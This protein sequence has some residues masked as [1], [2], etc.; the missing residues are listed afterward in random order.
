M[1]SSDIPLLREL[2]EQLRLLIECA[3]KLPP[4][5]ERDTALGDLAHYRERID[6]IAA[7]YCTEATAEVSN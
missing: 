3:D 5:P 4:S 1:K 7:R 2:V 6:T